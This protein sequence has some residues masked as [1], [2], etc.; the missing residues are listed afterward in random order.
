MLLNSYRTRGVN[1]AFLV[2]PPRT[3]TRQTGMEIHGAV[4]EALGVD[5][6]SFQYS[7][8]KNQP[9]A[10][11]FTIHLGREQDRQKLVVEI[12]GPVQKTPIRLFFGYDWPESTQLV[13]QDFDLM[14]EAVFSVLGDDWQR[15]LAEARVRGQAHA[16]GDSAV[17]F[18][19]RNVV[20]LPESDRGDPDGKPSFVALKYETTAT[21]FPSGDPLASPKRDVSVEVLRNDPRCIYVEVMSQW[22]Q[23][24]LSPGGAVQI[25]PAKIRTFQSPPSEYLK[26][27]LEYTES[28]VL[29]FLEPSG[30]KKQP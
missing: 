24:A 18:L 20:R 14:C 6:I 4:C 19:S 13:F 12:N 9:G 27:T 11:A 29:P 23:L 8:G 7:P 26:D 22:P 30:P 17:S 2:G 3:L 1:F 10:T 21:D 16:R 5:D 15:V 25:D 28:V